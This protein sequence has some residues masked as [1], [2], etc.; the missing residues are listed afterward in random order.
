MRSSIRIAVILLILC[1]IG[2]L[3]ADEWADDPYIIKMENRARKESGTSNKI[4]VTDPSQTRTPNIT[5]KII[6]NGFKRYE[7]PEPR[8]FPNEAAAFLPELPPRAI[9]FRP[10][11]TT[12]PSARPSPPSPDEPGE[13]LD[14]RATDVLVSIPNAR[15]QR[16]PHC[17]TGDDGV[18]YAVWGEEISSSAN[19]IMFSKS[20]DEGNTWSTAIVV[21]NVG[22]NYSPRVAVYGTGASARVHVVYNY[23]DWHV[24]D[25]Y[26]TM[27]TYLYSD[28]VAEG[29]VYYC[30]STTGGATFGH[31]QAIANNDIDL[32]IMHFN[33]DEG[34]ADINVDDYDNV[35]ISYYGQA[36]EG[37]IMSIALMIIII[38]LYEGL[39]PFWIDYTWYEV[40]MRA[41]TNHG[42]SFN[43]Q[44]EIVNEW[45]MDNSLAGSDIELSGSAATLHVVYTATGLLSLGSATAYY[46]QVVNPF[47]SPSNA[48]DEYVADGYPVPAG[49]RVDSLGNPRVGI[50][51]ISGWGY[52]VY[53][54]FS[55]DGGYTWP[56]PTT[57]AASSADEWE[58]KLRLDDAA[59]T[60]LV[61]SDERH[62]DTD[63]YCV[64]S[65]DGGWTLRPDQHQVNQSP[66]SYDQLWPGIGLFLSD[67][68]RRLDVVWWDERTD[69]DGDIYYNGAK[70]WRTNLNVMLHDSLANPMG[71]TV[72]LS[73]TSFGVFIE[74]EVSTGY[75][76]VYHDPGTEICLDRI[77]SGS[78]AVERW[79]YD[80]LDNFCVT[81]PVPGNTYD[82]IYYDQYY[83]TF[84]TVIGNAPACTASTIPSL[85]FTYEYFDLTE[86]EFTD[87]IGWANVRGEWHYTPAYP[88]DPDADMRW[89]CPEPDG[90]VLSPVVEPVYFFQFKATFL[91][92]LRLNDHECT[93]TV[94]HFTLTERWMGGTNI[95]GTTPLTDWTDCGS[96]YAYVD[97]KVISESQRWD[98]TIDPTGIVDGL[99]PYQPGAY[100]QW[101]PTINL[102]GPY[103]PEN[104]TYCETLYVG[105]VRTG[106]ANLSGVYQP[107]ADCGSPLW[108][109]EFTTLGW[110]ARDPRV[111]DP[112]TSAFM[113][114]IRYG[115]VVTVILEND[116][117]YG[118]LIADSVEV[119]SGFPLGWA[120]TSEHHICAVSPQVFGSTRFVFTHWSDLGDTCHDV[121][122]VG[123]TTWTAYFDKEYF[124]DII[125]D[126]GSPW[127]E[128]WYPEGT[129]AN[130]GVD[131]VTDTTGG[132]RYVFDHWE[133]TGTGSYTGPDTSADVTMDNPITET[134]YWNSQFRLIL[135]YTGTDTLVPTQTGEGW[136]AGGE[137]PLITTDSII[138]D[139][140]PDDT[141][142]YVFDHW[143]STPS[144]ATFGN[145]YHA[146]TQIYIGMP[147]TATA[148]YVRQWSFTVESTDSSLGSPDPAI[149]KH[150]Y[151]DGDTVHA[152]VTSPDGGMY[153]TGYL[154]YG[155]L[156]DGALSWLNF[157]ITQPSGVTWLWGEQYEFTV[158]SDPYEWVMGM[159][160][161]DPPA[162]TYYYIPGTSDEFSVDEFTS[163]MAGYRY[164]CDGWIGTGP[165]AP[166]GDT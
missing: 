63:I 27:G 92:P 103:M 8:E 78:D 147:Y 75:H 102:I 157:A 95:G 42:G 153:C 126:H 7:L 76:I 124:L 34:G 67:T 68:I 148:V 140:G 48:M 56:F 156:S 142:R 19:A 62:V 107:W 114:I 159:A 54:A 152:E 81:P 110:V 57:V 106:E 36:D 121:I 50:T 44:H 84:T 162:G 18:I 60:F 72:T 86:V 151:N 37:H 155:S 65:E 29:D 66:G 119:T 15:P 74:R 132:V 25:Y 6:A 113:A 163:E 97:P 99:G 143:E 127:G 16:Q 70:W 134:A 45:F 40:D 28:T 52:D 23:V 129:V 133:G 38:I 51:D 96:N 94:P 32:I 4:I 20:T 108:M 87:Y 88:S 17:V 79:I 3:F 82:V 21:D 138:G 85:A 112:V 137:S 165:A 73:Y 69:P 33:Y 146:N 117:G 2:G 10:A 101:R 22:T 135:D 164:R 111:F 39:P 47:F 31:Y 55:S 128:G 136:Y 161:P 166:D 100:H 160:S 11:R 41:S 13:G 14:F 77:S 90:I 53:Y 118:V 1:F 83:T 123:D 64:W 26:D 49:V 116:F 59:N 150:W 105:G 89:Y 115:N 130:F 145:M 80:T 122:P 131:S 58:P 93:H 46:K 91:D 154:G 109:G 5:E 71:G 158:T 141:L 35:C 9:E 104:P 125:S 139:D 43:S 149:G 12:P 144:G 120:P 30:R 61:W 98:I 24:Y